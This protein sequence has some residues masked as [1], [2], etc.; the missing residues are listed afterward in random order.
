MSLL[1]VSQPKPTFLSVDFL[2]HA[3]IILTTFFESE[4]AC[5]KPIEILPILPLVLLYEAFADVHLHLGWCLR[6][7]FIIPT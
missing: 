1:S 6:F 7:V 5:G 3:R 4:R 2:S